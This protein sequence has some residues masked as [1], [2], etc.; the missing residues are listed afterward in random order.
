MHSRVND[1]PARV[2]SLLLALVCQVSCDLYCMS[3][4]ESGKEGEWGRKKEIGWAGE[5]EERERERERGGKWDD[6]EVSLC[7]CMK[8][9]V[10]LSPHNLNLYLSRLFLSSPPSCL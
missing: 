1:Q 5:D 7:M 10:S 4:R 8:E 9:R 2:S 6:R 3:V